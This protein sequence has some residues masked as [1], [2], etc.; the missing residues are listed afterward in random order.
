MEKLYVSAN[1]LLDDS[2]RLADQI[3]KSGFKPDYVVGVW[4]GGTPIGIAVQ[5]YL[6]YRG[7]QTDH[8]AMRAISYY[9]ISK[10]KDVVQVHGLEYLKERLNSDHKV[11]I[12]DDVFETGHTLVAIMNELQLALG[13][14]TPQ[15][16][17]LATVYWK[18]EHNQTKVTPDFYVNSTEEW[19]VFP[20][21]MDGL[22]KEEIFENKSAVLREL[23]ED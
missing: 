21:E 17:K 7:V 19:I 5:E 15:N 10:R 12:V 9:G 22:T 14:K 13:G 11:V 2:Y 1:Q 16:I 4:R 23:L 20:H 3:Y 6:D 8:C 18:P